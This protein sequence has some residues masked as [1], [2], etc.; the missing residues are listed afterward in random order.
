MFIETSKEKFIKGGIFISLSLYK[1]YHISPAFVTQISKRILHFSKFQGGESFKASLALALG[2]SDEN[3][4]S[5]D[6]VH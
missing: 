6:G 5:A 1:V 4:S 3:Q 2:L